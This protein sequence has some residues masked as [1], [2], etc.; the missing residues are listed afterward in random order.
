MKSCATGFIVR[1]FKVMIPT[2]LGGT[3]TLIGKTLTERYLTL[4]CTS[5]PGSVVRY[6][7]FATKAACIGMP[8]KMAP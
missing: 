1:R 3:G 7:P 2:G 8:A 5:D 4:K 6:G